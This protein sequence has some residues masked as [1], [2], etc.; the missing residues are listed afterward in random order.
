MTSM[1]SLATTKSNQRFRAVFVGARLLASGL[2]LLA[3]AGCRSNEADVRTT[4]AARAA[5]SAAMENGPTY[6][7][8]GVSTDAMKKVTPFDSARFGG[9]TDTHQFH[10][11][12]HRCG[13]C[14]LPPNPRMH[15]AYEWE[16][17]VAQMERTIGHA[18]L[19]PIAPADRATIM[20]FLTQH[21]LRGD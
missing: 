4:M 15:R 2:V 16:G 6:L 9:R 17:V 14:H 3:V 8:A 19:L 10:T 5:V 1:R 12:K 18:G 13:A 21:A 7:L 11:F 20:E